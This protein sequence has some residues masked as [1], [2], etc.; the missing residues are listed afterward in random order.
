[1]RTKTSSFYVI[2][3]LAALTVALCSVCAS[4][5]TTADSI[6]LNGKIYTV[7]KSFSSVNAIAV[8]DGK[9][10]F[11][12]SNGG[13]QALAGKQTKVVDLGGKAVIPGLDDSHLHFLNLGQ[14]KLRIQA[15][16]K[17]KE[18]ILKAVK[19]A[20]AKA[21]PG[22]WI[23]GRGWNQ[24][25]WN[26]AEFPTRQDLDAVALNVPVA[27]VRT[28]GHASWVNSKA[29]E[30][31]GVTKD[32]PNPTGGEFLRD[33]DGVPTGVMTD[34]AQEVI[35]K[36]IPAYTEVQNIDAL[37]AA[38]KE[39]FG[40]GLTSASSAGEN[41]GTIDLMKKLYKENKLKV[42]LDV[43]A[44]VTGR[45]SPEELIAGARKFFKQGTQVGLFNDRLQIRSYKIS[46]DGSLGARSAWMLEDYSDRK[47]H[48]GNGKLTDEQLYTLVKEGNDAGFQ[49][50]THAIGDATNRQV[51]D[52][53]EKV[54][55]ENPRKDHR[56]RIEH[57]QIL[58]PK[59]LPRF[60]KLGVLPAMQTCHATSDMNMAED[61]VG[62]ERIKY[63]YAWR[64]IL[65]TGSIIPNGT[66]A[67]VE[68]VDPWICLHAAV[69]RTDSK[70]KPAGGWYPEEKMTRE[71]ALRS[72]TIWAAYASFEEN[73]KGS[74]EVGKLA[75]FIVLDRDYMKCPATEIKDIKVLRTVVGG[76]T[77]YTK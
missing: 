29:L 13:A 40:Y 9:I 18:E 15:H 36:L 20:A 50:C 26:P 49:L 65:K 25:V 75:D 56:F 76:E 53:Y 11:A 37:M 6:W 41:Q 44:R 42:R 19:A 77:V 39:L 45:P 64:K 27:I 35:N 30:L 8:K 58:S 2:I 69:T 68:P 32:T 24:M 23:V 55:K 46:A 72:Y 33:K 66:D 62:H 3:C 21:R 28:C 7:D 31:A 61:R 12:G 74:L 38:Q 43:M 34:Q 51:L 70:L 60:V 4:A 1:M 59:D 54:L 5:A 52:I 73:K 14:S 47:G 48:R 71:E 57:A 17:P 63:S 16:W 10:I 22:E 67:P